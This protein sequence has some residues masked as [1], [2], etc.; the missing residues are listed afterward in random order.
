[1]HLI[2]MVDT[3][4][5][6]HQKFV[7][8]MRKR[9]YPLKGILRDGTTRP[10]PCEIKLYDI[11]IKS[12]V[13]DEFLRDIKHLDCIGHVDTNEKNVEKMDDI[14]KTISEVTPLEYVDMKKIEKRPEKEQPEIGGFVYLQVMGKL[15]DPKD[16]TGSDVL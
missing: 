16:N 8:W 15:K 3:M 2:L 1:M 11:R 12:E 9:E 10:F 7:D 5:E 6:T 14:K 4:P 13:A